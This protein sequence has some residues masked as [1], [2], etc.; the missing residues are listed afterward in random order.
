MRR[1]RVRSRRVRH[2]DEIVLRLE[3]P[4]LE[5]EPVFHAGLQ[6]IRRGTL[7]RGPHALDRPG[8]GPLGNGNGI[9]IGNQ[10]QNRVRIL[11]RLNLADGD[12]FERGELELAIKREVDRIGGQLGLG[13]VAAKDAGACRAGTVMYLNNLPGKPVS[14]E[15]KR[16]A[17]EDD[18]QRD[19][20]PLFPRHKRD[21]LTLMRPGIFERGIG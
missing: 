5:Q 2:G 3:L 8:V 15:I 12:D 10:V 7:H 18:G 13:P 1:G 19:Q 4:G 20:H 17:A 9:G 11:V 6:R 16:K 21:G 14:V